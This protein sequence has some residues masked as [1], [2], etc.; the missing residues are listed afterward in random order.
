MKMCNRDNINLVSTWNEDDAVGEAVEAGTSD[1][2]PEPAPRF[3]V[4][5][6]VLERS[7]DLVNKLDAQVSALLRIARRRWSFRRRRPEGN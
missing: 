2:P 1:I 6:K 7:F 4:R 5:G 3:R